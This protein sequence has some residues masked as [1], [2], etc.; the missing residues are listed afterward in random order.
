MPRTSKKPGDYP[1]G[2]NSQHKSYTLE[3]ITVGSFGLFCRTYETSERINLY[4]G[5]MEKW[6]THVQLIREPLSS[7][8]SLGY[9]IK[10][11]YDSLCSLSKN[12]ERSGNTVMIVKTML[13]YIA[14]KYPTVTQLQ[15]NDLSQRTCDNQTEA[16]LGVMTYLYLGKTWYMK[17]FNATIHP[18]SVSF[19]EQA[20]DKLNRAKIENKWEKMRLTITNKEGYIPMTDVEMGKLYDSSPTWQVFFRTILNSADIS[21]FCMFFSEWQDTFIQMYFNNLVSVSFLMPVVSQGFE[22]K[23][24]EYRAEGGRRK[25]QTRKRV[26]LK[27]KEGDYHPDDP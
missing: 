18:D 4:F 19:M 22:Y 15:F 13:Q 2:E 20:V 16:F 1:T 27:V 25:K 17:H 10:V 24:N 5:G 7:P 6:C 21:L 3:K 12:T 23:I 14:D 8:K 26:P 11:R 9:L